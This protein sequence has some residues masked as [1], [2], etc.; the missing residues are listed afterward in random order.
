MP[1]IN[2]READIEP[3]INLDTVENA[4]LIFG[5]DFH[6]YLAVDTTVDKLTF[7]DITK[8]PEADDKNLDKLVYDG[9]TYKLYT[10]LPDFLKD[11]KTFKELF[12]NSDYPYDFSNELAYRPY[13]T[14]YDCLL[15]GLPVIYVPI[16]DYI[17]DSLIITHT[18]SDE[19]GI[20]S[21]TRYIE[22]QW[23]MDIEIAEDSAYWDGANPLHL[24]F[25]G[26]V[27]EEIINQYKAIDHPAE[28]ALM[29][30]LQNE[31]A[32]NILPLSDRINMP[33][34]FITTCGWEGQDEYN[35]FE[36]EIFKLTVMTEKPLQHRLDMLYLYDLPYNISPS[37]LTSDYSKLTITCPELVNIVYPWG[38]Y[39]LYGG[40]NNIHMPGSYGWLMAYA[41]SIKN[42][43]PWL[44]TAGVNRGR[45]PNVVALDYDV[46]E[47]YLHLWQGDNIDTSWKD[48]N[49]RVNPIIDLGANYGKVIFGNRTCFPENTDAVVFRTFLN[50]RL[51]L[52]YLHKQIFKVSMR[53]MFEP[54]DDIVWLS[55]KQAANTLLDK[56]VTGR[57]IQ[58]Y[59]WQRLRPED[60]QGNLILGQIKAKLTIRPIEAVE[61][62]DITINMTDQEIE[63]VEGEE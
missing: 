2:I 40:A 46:R 59:K 36:P 12:N 5:F 42:N 9:R 24:I 34:T 19:S 6:R 53:H 18:K 38:H 56:M 15:R 45:I 29:L 55:F 3:V 62:F 37:L 47:S 23:L 16:D 28:R 33:I 54:N 63:V 11:I 43:F 1:Y 48:A 50:V 31:N 20:I 7:R 25:D 4:V 51:L 13:R 30:M 27:K 8:R 44:A 14:A 41:T 49:I 39:N 52:I 60:S 26:D 61:S 57:G 32:K 35:N 58:W 21:T 17:S 10:S 22:Y